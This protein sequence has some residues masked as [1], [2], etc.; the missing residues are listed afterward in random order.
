MKSG[1]RVVLSADGAMQISS[2]T[3]RQAL[4]HPVPPW[5][6]FVAHFLQDNGIDPANSDIQMP[7]G[8]LARVFY[9]GE[10]RLSWDMRQED[11]TK[12]SVETV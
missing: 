6:M 9:D 8:R 4:N 7:D 11:G 2:P 1:Y 10:G 3:G 12:R 5:I